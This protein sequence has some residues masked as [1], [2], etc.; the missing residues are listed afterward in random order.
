MAKE[1]SLSELSAKLAEALNSP[2]QSAQPAS[3]ASSAPI[4]LMHE[5]A[6]LLE[7]DK[8]IDGLRRELADAKAEFELAVDSIDPNPWQARTSFDQDKMA[9]LIESIAHT[10]LVEPIV[11]RRITGEG[12]I[13][14]YQLGAGERRWHAHKELKKEAIRAVIVDV[15]H[16]SQAAMSWAE[17]VCRENLADFEIYR[18]IARSQGAFPSRTKMAEAM[19]VHRSQLYRYLAF[20]A[21]PD[22]IKADLNANPTYLGSNGA[23]AIVRLIKKHGERAVE[24]LPAVW[25]RV[26]NGQ[27]D[28]AKIT[29]AAESMLAGKPVRERGIRTVSQVFDDKGQ[30]ALITNDGNLFSIKVRLRALTGDRQAQLEKL[31]QETLGV[32]LRPA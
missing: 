13:A 18:A 28:Q 23:D 20:E 17:N 2:G 19:G 15:D 26:K 3:K 21:L 14:R 7:R 25:K 4:K 9:E 6:A 1:K 32:E 11:V 16:E 24:I 31:I 5:R 10:G 12:G 22:F 30:V 27:L 29:S 8:R